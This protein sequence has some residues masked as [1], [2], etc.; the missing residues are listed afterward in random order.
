MVTPGDIEI[1]V[2]DA[3][4]L[5]TQAHRVMND[6]V[7]VTLVDL[8]DLRKLALGVI[9]RIDSILAREAVPT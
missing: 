2:A 7:P 9:E 3:D 5:A 1:V 8:G 4:D 6:A